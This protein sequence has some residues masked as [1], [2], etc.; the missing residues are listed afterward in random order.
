MSMRLPRIEQL[1]G[2]ST[3][4]FEASDEDLWAGF[5]SLVDAAV[6]E[7]PD[8]DFKGAWWTR[9]EEIAKDCAAMANSLGGV[10]LI[11]IEDESRDVAASLSGTELRPGQDLTVQQAV[12]GNSAPKLPEL[13]VRSVADPEDPTRGV[14][15]VGIQ[16]SASAPHAVTFSRERLG[17]PVRRSTSTDWLL[18]Y[19]IAQRYRNRFDLAV[20]QQDRAIDQLRTACAAINR[21]ANVWLVLGLVPGFSGTMSLSRE[22]VERTEELVSQWHHQK[23]QLTGPVQWSAPG[24]RIRR[25]RIVITTDQHAS[26]S[27]TEHHELWLDGSGTS[28]SVVGVA[29]G[30]ATNRVANADL[31]EVELAVVTQL[32]LLVSHAIRAGAVG[33]AVCSGYLLPAWDDDALD[34]IVTTA[35]PT[36]TSPPARVGLPMSITGSMR[37][38]VD[39]SPRQRDTEPAQITVPIDALASSGEELV[40][41][42]RTLALAI[43]AEDNVIDP[44]LFR[45]AGAIDIDWAEVHLRR[46]FAAWAEGRG[47]PLA[48]RPTAAGGG[49]S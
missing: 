44:V 10:I 33:D 13:H 47:I 27:A 4:L 12:A 43:L 25:G 46:A 42:A 20:G 29:S 21:A 31:S 17:Y 24:V 28:G 8:L 30:P 37:R 15:M 1:F 45:Q 26:L 6:P 22:E 9:P 36:R 34:D 18:E 19:E 23:P 41:A 39:D 11:G 16:R 7:G 3:S 14:V 38:S 35:D 32:D 5:A 48:A 2:L 40:S 49:K